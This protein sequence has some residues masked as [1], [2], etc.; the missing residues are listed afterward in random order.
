M[1]GHV[2]E[3]GVWGHESGPPYGDAHGHVAKIDDRTT[4]HSTEWN[5]G[6]GHGMGKNT[7]EATTQPMHGGIGRG[8][9]RRLPEG[10]GSWQG[11]KKQVASWTKASLLWQRGLYSRSQPSEGRHPWLSS[12]NPTVLVPGFPWVS[13]EWTLPVIVDREVKSPFISFLFIHC[14]QAVN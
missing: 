11:L 9:R 3:A 5:D 1:L 14:S 4:N 7:E 13:L 2:I 6:G 8:E 12:I 10:G